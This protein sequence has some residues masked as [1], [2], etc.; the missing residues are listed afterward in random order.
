MDNFR[1]YRKVNNHLEVEMIKSR[2]IA[3]SLVLFLVLAL[4]FTSTADADKIDKLIIA[5]DIN[6][7]PYEFMDEQGNYSGFN[8][9]IMRAISIELG[10]EIVLVPMEWNASIEALKNGEVDAIQ[11]MTQSAERE[12]IFDFSNP[13]IENSQQIFVHVDNMSIRSLRDLEGKTVAFQEGDVNNEWIRDVINISPVYKKD[14]SEAM[15]ALIDGEVDAFVGNRYTGLYNIQKIN[16][17]DKVKIVGEG[18]GNKSYA[19]VVIDGNTEVL[20]EIN[21]GIS[22]IKN[23]GTYDKIYEKWFGE[24]FVDKTRFWRK[25]MIFVVICLLISL[26]IAIV[27]AYLNRKLKSEVHRRTKEIIK[28]QKQIEDS[29]RFR[30]QILES[31]DNGIVAFDTDGKINSINAAAKELLSKR[32]LEAS[33]FNQILSG[34][35]VS[36][37]SSDVRGS[38]VWEEDSSSPIYLDYKCLPI[39]AQNDTEGAI[40]VIRDTTV[41]KHL[42]S[43]INQK[44]KMASIGRLSAG[45]AHELRN[46][47]TAIKALVDMMPTRLDSPKFTSRMQKILP[48]EINRLNALVDSLLDYAKP[49]PPNPQKFV[50]KGVI[51]NVLSLN[52]VFLSENNVELELDYDNDL[53]ATADRYQIK[54]VL[55][56]LIRNSVDAIISKNT[57]GLIKISTFLENDFCIIEISDNG[58]GIPREHIKNIFEP[59]FTLKAQGYGIGLSICQ[60]LILENNG[61]IIIDSEEGKGTSVKLR[62]PI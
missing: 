25:L 47:L 1:V 61:E 16:Q 35:G 21:K 55:I 58:S 38:Y 39:H 34:L 31:I 51:E 22:I 28:Q 11:G 18:V 44:D 48:L 15:L 3:L 7:P 17:T 29:N 26:G 52:S 9:D 60:Q 30:G 27:V 2:I 19:S 57:E 12:S 37:F 10:I 20:K 62:L 59:F 6:Y 5:G 32:N 33:N 36:D 13:L 50:V 49:K 54:Q 53:T 8:V 45:I 14:Q 56:N 4:N 46:P 43:I 24:H 40:L 23:N 41:E 42:Q